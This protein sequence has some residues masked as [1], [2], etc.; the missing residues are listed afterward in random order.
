MI[1]ML[2]PVYVHP[3]MTMFFAKLLGCLQSKESILS[4]LPTTL[5]AP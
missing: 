2:A 4:D 1:P 3:N 5:S